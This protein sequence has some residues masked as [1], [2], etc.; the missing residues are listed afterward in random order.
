MA[1]KKGKLSKWNLEQAVPSA[2]SDDYGFETLKK[3]VDYR[4]H[5]FKIFFVSDT[6]PVL[7]SASQTLSPTL[8]NEFEMTLAINEGFVYDL[9]LYDPN[10]NHP[11]LVTKRLDGTFLF[12]S[13]KREVFQLKDLERMKIPV[14]IGTQT[15]TEVIP[16]APGPTITLTIK[17]KG[18]FIDFDEYDLNGMGCL[19]LEVIFRNIQ[20][21]VA[22]KATPISSA[23]IL[24]AEQIR[25]KY[26]QATSFSGG[27]VF[28]PGE[29]S[30]NR[31]R[32][33]RIY[34]PDGCR[35][36]PANAVSYKTFTPAV[37][38]TEGPYQ[39]VFYPMPQADQKTLKNHLFLRIS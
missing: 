17:T 14:K 13:Q 15:M 34:S 8:K 11:L 39:F 3:G 2:K 18:E 6:A 31:T 28:V 12:L 32:F 10:Y 27:E 19:F 35:F 26:G 21:S 4:N 23:T 37:A 25:Q 33:I 38:A 29:F 5:P 22:G 20:V 1:F 16:G 30:R 24:T 36:I 7:E 9:S